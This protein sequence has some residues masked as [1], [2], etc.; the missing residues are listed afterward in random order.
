MSIWWYAAAKG[1]MGLQSLIMRNKDQTRNRKAAARREMAK[2]G[3]HPLSQSISQSRISS[4]LRSLTEQAS[5]TF[6]RGRSRCD[7]TNLMTLEDIQNS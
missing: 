3:F 7:K 5:A 1:F 6:S 2:L 4:D